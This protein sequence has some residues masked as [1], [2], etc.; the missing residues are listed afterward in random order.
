MIWLQGGTCFALWIAYGVLQNRRGLAIKAWAEAIPRA[1]RGLMA[2]AIMLG[3]MVPIFI[4]LNLA[5][6]HGGFSNN[7]MAPVVWLSVAIFGLAFVH[8]QTLATALLVISAMESVTATRL[9]ASR[10]QTIQENDQHEAPS[11]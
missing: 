6:Q 3:A 10:T 4:V 9:E 1:K 11:P 2:A 7:G 8:G 5:L